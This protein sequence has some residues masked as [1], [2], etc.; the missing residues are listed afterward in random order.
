MKALF[1]TEDNRL[2]L[3][4]LSDNSFCLYDLDERRLLSFGYGQDDR[5]TAVEWS[6]RDTNDARKTFYTLSNDL[7]IFIWHYD[8][9]E[10]KTSF[11]DIA[12]EVLLQAA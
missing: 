3:Q 5:V 2:S 4:H 9:L 6:S 1:S 11:L 12:K 8:A 10:W 7:S